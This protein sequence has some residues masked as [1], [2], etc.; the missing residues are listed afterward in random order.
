MR[1]SSGCCA[2]HT[3]AAMPPAAAP[4]SVRVWS[5]AIETKTVTSARQ[6]GTAP[7]DDRTSRSGEAALAS[8]RSGRQSAR[9]LADPRTL[10]ALLPPLLPALADRPRARAP[11]GPGDLRRQSPVVPRSVRD[12]HDRAA[13][14]VLRR[15]AR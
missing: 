15:Q 1:L 14:D 8:A 9:L 6:P 4:R 10:P 7:R 12:R 11:D 3:A 5:K 13:A 2:A